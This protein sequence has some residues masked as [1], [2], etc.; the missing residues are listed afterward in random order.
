MKQSYERAS[1]SVVTLAPIDIITTS[2]PSNGN[3]KDTIFLPED[4]F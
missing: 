1:M 3:E 4:I 2:G